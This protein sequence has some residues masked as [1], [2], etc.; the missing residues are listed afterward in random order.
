MTRGPLCGETKPWYLRTPG[1]LGLNDA[2]DLNHPVFAWGSPGPLG[3]EWKKA[4][5][6]KP[7]SVS[8]REQSKPIRST[9]DA[10]AN[11]KQPSAAIIKQLSADINTVRKLNEAAGTKKGEDIR[12]KKERVVKDIVTAYGVGLKYTT[13]LDFSNRTGYPN[14]ADTLKGTFIVVYDSVLDH[15]PGYVANVILH[16]SSHAQRN[17][18]LKQV[19]GVERDRLKD[20]DAA[21]WSALI[22]FEATQLELDNAPKTGITQAEQQEAKSLRDGHLKEINALMGEKARTEIENGGLDTVRA[23]FMQKLKSPR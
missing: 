15:P 19:T 16:E 13:G 18:E 21:I 17:T 1:P 10:V 6:A 11:L 2:A 22:E 9:V 3:L 14:D 20:G 12:L 8:E 4:R 5:K 23:R 7:K